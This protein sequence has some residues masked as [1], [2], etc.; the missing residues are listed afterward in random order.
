VRALALP[1]GEGD[2]RAPLDEPPW[3]A[4]RLSALLVENARRHPGKI[5]FRDQP[6][7]EAWSGRPRLEWT[8]SLAATAI[9]RLATFFASLGLPPGS[10]IGICLPSGSEAAITILAGEQAG[11][12]PCL[13]PAA[14]REGDLEE[15]LAGAGIQAVATQG[16]IG[17]ERPAELFCAIA[18]RSFGLRFL[19]AYGPSV[20]DGVIDLDRIIL[21]EPAEPRADPQP[22]ELRHDAGLITFSAHSGPGTPLHRSGASLAASTAA[23]LM[24]AKIRSGDRIL[25]L[26][27][28]D[29]LAGLSTGL[30]A[31][32]LSGATLECH[33]LFD[34]AALLTSCDA[35]PPTHLVAPGWIGP[36]LGQSGLAGRL[37]S[38]VFVHRAPIRFA[39]KTRFEGR[40]LDVVALDEQ[41][42]L[43]GTRD[44]AGTAGLAIDDAGKTRAEGS[45][46]R[47]RR[48]EDGRLWLAGLASAVRPYARHGMRDAQL[49]AEWRDSG[50]LADVSAGAVV[51]ISRPSCETNLRDG[52]SRTP[53]RQGG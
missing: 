2:D 12:C 40:V 14:W 43:T 7:R 30:V 46:L 21:A 33:G 38:T 19:C 41:A 51:G 44:E 23:Y 10:P 27:A 9:A 25:T 26:L 17:N 45:L 37:A 47:M 13:L 35:G 24:A 31:S 15:A 18:A 34:G 36:A 16:E 22:A 53:T 6:D 1:A 42:L 39:A 48:H 20:P 49:V 8:H 4:I 50:F 11:F 29:D 28:P 5:A 52:R 32:L 3:D